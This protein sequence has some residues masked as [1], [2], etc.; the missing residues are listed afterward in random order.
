MGVWEDCEATYA[1]KET[2]DSGSHNS[3]TSGRNCDN[4]KLLPGWSKKAIIYNGV[5]FSVCSIL[6][7]FGSIKTPGANGSHHVT[8]FR[9]RET[10]N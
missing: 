7:S 9:G 5:R 2:N 8:R 3:F 6:T 10:E 4:S 1:T